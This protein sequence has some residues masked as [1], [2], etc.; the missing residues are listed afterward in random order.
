M[1]YQNNS[2]QTLKAALSFS[3][4][5]LVSGFILNGASITFTPNGSQHTKLQLPQQHFNAAPPAQSANT[6]IGTLGI[7][8]DKKIISNFQQN[9]QVL[10]TNT[11]FRY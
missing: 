4:I 10:K 2:H 7:S 5:A 3:F 9:S 11:S 6:N 1:R 8:L